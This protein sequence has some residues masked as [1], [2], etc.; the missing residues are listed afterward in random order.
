MDNDKKK[1]PDDQVVIWHPVYGTD[2]RNYFDRM[3]GIGPAFGKT[4]EETIVMTRVD[5]LKLIER[6]P[7]M[8]D[9]E[10]ELVKQG[11]EEW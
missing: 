9:W 1:H 7:M 3:T 5:A 10:F 4:R 6:F 2:R 11:K 8:V